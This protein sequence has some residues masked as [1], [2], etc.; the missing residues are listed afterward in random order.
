MIIIPLPADKCRK[1]SDERPVN[2]AQE[3]R[4]SA[5][6]ALTFELGLT[7]QVGILRLDLIPS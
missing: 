1:G 2:S 7:K 3:I 6:K 5:A 4:G